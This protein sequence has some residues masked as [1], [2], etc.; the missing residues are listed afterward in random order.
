MDQE[1]ARM[2][3]AVEAYLSLCEGF[4]KLTG[5]QP[6]AE[7]LSDQSLRRALGMSPSETPAHRVKPKADLQPLQEN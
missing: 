7:E 1:L 2:A 6:T 3:L 4:K 5:R